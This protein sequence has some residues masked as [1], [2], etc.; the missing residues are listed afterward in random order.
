M[1]KMIFSVLVCVALVAAACLSWMFAKSDIQCLL[2]LIA[3]FFPYPYFEEGR[4]EYKEG[5]R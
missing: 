5:R 4:K 1:K 2:F 3:S